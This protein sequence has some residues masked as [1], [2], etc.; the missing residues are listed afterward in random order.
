MKTYGGAEVKLHT[1]LT[2]AIVSDLLPA[3]ATHPEKDT[4]CLVNKGFGWVPEP[5]LSRSKVTCVTVVRV[6]KRSLQIFVDLLTLVLV[7][8]FAHKSVVILN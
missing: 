6:K 3:V 7:R 8:K 5:L 4:N 2:S 1:F